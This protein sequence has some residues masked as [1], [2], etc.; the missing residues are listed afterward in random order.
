MH[1]RL[2]KVMRNTIKCTE[3]GKNVFEN[4][5]EIKWQQS[6]ESMGEKKHIRDFNWRRKMLKCHNE[7]KQMFNK[8]KKKWKH[9]RMRKR[10]IKT[11]VINTRRKN[12]MKNK[13]KE[14]EKR[15]LHV[16]Y[17]IDTAD[18]ITP[19]DWHKFT[20][21]RSLN[22]TQFI[23]YNLPHFAACIRSNVDEIAIHK[24]AICNPFNFAQKWTS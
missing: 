5:W 12:Q 4:Q 20:V 8:Q 6:N 3:N 11:Q 21:H 2:A 17:W 18:I 22:Y 1:K 16:W 19:I 24:M 23:W 10:K 7:T 13:I 15:K 14:E 9:I